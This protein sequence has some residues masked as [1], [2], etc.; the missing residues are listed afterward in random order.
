M[1]ISRAKKL[2][3][4]SNPDPDKVRRMI[5]CLKSESNYIQMCMD[6]GL[7]D[8]ESGEKSINEISGLINELEN[9]L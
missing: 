1:T 2:I 4:Q 8:I 7:R 6:K 9:K 5:E 3:T